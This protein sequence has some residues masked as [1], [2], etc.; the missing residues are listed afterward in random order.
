MKARELIINGSLETFDGEPITDQQNRHMTI[1]RALLVQLA[2]SR[3]EGEERFEVFRLGLDIGKAVKTQE[4]RIILA[5]SDWEIL[6]RVVEANPAGYT[7]MIFVP[8][9]KTV[10]AGIE[11]EVEKV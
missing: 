7:D 6:K 8:V 2:A 10:L 3:S 11:F 9:V 5:E 4:E 1:G